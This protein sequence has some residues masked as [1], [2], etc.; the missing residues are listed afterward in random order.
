LQPADAI[1]VPT[2]NSHTTT[3]S[4][5]ATPQ[6]TADSGLPIETPT[7]SATSKPRP[8]AEQSE[9]AADP[10]SASPK[11]NV[12]EASNTS[13]DAPR[14]GETKANS[15]VDEETKASS[16][17]EEQEPQVN[18]GHD[19]A[20]STHLS[21]KIGP[22]DA[23]QDLAGGSGT[24]DSEASSAYG[25]PEPVATSLHTNKQLESSEGAAAILSIFLTRGSQGADTDSGPQVT[26]ASDPE[27]ENGQGLVV[28]VSSE[29]HAVLASQGG[30][31]ID[32]TRLADGQTTVIS[33]AIAGTELSVVGDGIVVGSSTATVHEARSSATKFGTA[34]TVNGD[35]YLASALP[36]QNNVMLVDG[37]TLS[38]D[39][40]AATIHGQVI[41]YGSEGLSI[42]S[43][44]A[45][46]TVDSEMYSASALPDQND[47]MIVDGHTLPKGGAAARIH[48]QVIAYGSEGLSIL[49]SIASAT[50]NGEMHAASNLPNQFGT[51]LLDGH[52]LSQGG[53]PVSI[54]GHIVTYGSK[55]LSVA[56]STALATAT[57]IAE[58]GKLT[59]ALDGTAYT[60]T[61]VPGSSG[62]VILQGQTL[63][64]GG[65]G[66]TIA[67]QFVTK[68]S[69][70]ISVAVSTSMATASDDAETVESAATTGMAGSYTSAIQESPAVPDEESS[71]SKLKPGLGTFWLGVAMLMLMMSLC[72]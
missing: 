15:L 70:G 48:G 40:A 5:A 62:G 32:E 64:I 42:L 72:E 68:G 46:V 37:H 39:G 18:Q 47:A 25:R 57:F 45:S 16:T 69:D 30:I 53:P 19:V 12:D 24:T 9:Q 27:S 41:A 3:T 50:V 4:P 11:A 44:I 8:Q 22:A 38:T 61:P 66:I 54:D 29:V 34:V 23:S 51:L 33:G 55:G 65:S 1:A 52:T 14:V 49:S 35:V 6:P 21:T 58:S 56:D 7:P 31:V 13:G 43:S 36:E 63:S 17:D 67:G 26:P 59:I 60:A 10:T 20:E 2:L 71:G 28:S